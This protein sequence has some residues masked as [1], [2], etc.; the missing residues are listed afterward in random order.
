MPKTGTHENDAAMEF[1]ASEIG[2]GNL[3][4]R[5]Y[6]MVEMMEISH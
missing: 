1:V 2:K 3:V 4:D 6:T 5:D